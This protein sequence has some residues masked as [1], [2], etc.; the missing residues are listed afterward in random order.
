MILALVMSVAAVFSPAAVEQYERLVGAVVTVK[1]EKSSNIGLLRLVTAESVVVE[2]R[3][4]VRTINAD[5]VLGIELWGIDRGPAFDAEGLRNRRIVELERFAERRDGNAL[6]AGGV[7]VLFSLLEVGV[8]YGWTSMLLYSDSLDTK[9]GLG[10]LT[11]F[12]A[13][14]TTWSWLYCGQLAGDASKAR[15]DI[16]VLKSMPL[17]SADEE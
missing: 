10:V 11:A 12:G 15:S 6:A 1:T 14:M 5:D 9:V 13:G 3:G 7:A 16:E 4:D 8:A 17:P 2:V